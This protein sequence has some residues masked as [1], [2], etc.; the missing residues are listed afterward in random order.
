M[1]KQLTI[2]AALMFAVACKTDSPSK[3]SSAAAGDDSNAKARS[4]KIEVK[5]LQP[6]AGAPAPPAQP[7]PPAPTAEPQAETNQP[8]GIIEPA[9]GDPVERDEWRRRRDVR[10]DANGD[11]EITP[12]ERQAARTN[13]MFNMRT[14]FD[15]NGD[16]KLSPDELAE[17]GRGRMRFDDPAAL[18]ANQDGDISAEELAAGFR[19]RREQARTRGSVEGAQG[20][21]S[22]TTP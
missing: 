7:A 16:G 19:M 6:P 3:S 21:A 17:R 13:R 10:L 14:R 5:P 11:G 8:P 18:D 20:S 15:T 22:G 4:A 2:V 12:E 9:S 1:M